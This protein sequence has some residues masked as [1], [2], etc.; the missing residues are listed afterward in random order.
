MLAS[1][2]LKLQL[3]QSLQ[4]ASNAPT[5]LTQKQLFLQ[6]LIEDE[7]A[8]P[9][10]LLLIRKLKTDPILQLTCPFRKINARLSVAALFL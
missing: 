4:P 8:G 3:V 6:R 2:C 7:V 10:S 5:T 9:T 1:C